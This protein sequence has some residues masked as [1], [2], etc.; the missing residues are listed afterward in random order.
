VEAPVAGERLLRVEGLGIQTVP[1][2][3]SESVTIVQ[4]AAFDLGRGE[5]LG[6][7]GESGSGKSSVAL[8]ILGLLPAGLRA[9][10]SVAF[11]GTEL[12]ELS[13]PDLRP[14]RGAE[15]GAVFQNPFRSLNP[16][17]RIGAQ[18]E[19]AVML[20]GHGRHSAEQT[21]VSLLEQVGLPDAERAA[22]SYPHALSGGMQQ[23]VAI[24]L[25][26][27]RNPRL[28][29]ADE[30]TTALDVRVQAQIL[31]LLVRLVRERDMALIL[32]SHDLGVV[33]SVADRIAVLY[34]GR[35]VESGPAAEVF[36]AAA[37]P[38]SHALL[39]SAPRLRG[40]KR[41]AASL[42]GAATPA[43]A[44]MDGC[45]FAPRCGYAVARCR[46]DEPPPSSVGDDGHRAACWVLPWTGHGAVAAPVEGGGPP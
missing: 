25:S 35:V 12:L 37:H 19:E 43:G 20:D 30:P 32:I 16:S 23:R 38:Y 18:L 40:P 44:A 39:E 42:R 34:S 6:I 24:A 8:A 17:I 22:A 46:S 7:V 1:R 26:I 36:G 31:E 33:A 29:I 45:R 9:S 27:A 4:D 28:L 3:R 13:E 5:T 21:T 15:I 2:R 14:M 10:G 41:L 11:D